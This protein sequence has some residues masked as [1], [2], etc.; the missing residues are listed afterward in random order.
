MS[1][2]TDLH[3][4]TPGNLIV[5]YQLDTTPIG[6]SDILHF[7]A[8]ANALGG[9]L[10]WGGVTY[11]HFPLEATGFERSGTGG[12]PRPK[13]VVANVDGL[14]GQFGRSLGGLEGAKLVRT[15]TFMKYLDPANFPGG[16]NPS[17]DSN[18]YIDREVWFISRR[19]SENRI[20]IEYELAASF[21]LGNVKLPRRQIVQ[22]VCTWRY[23]SA[24]CGYSGGPVADVKDVATAD[25][26]KDVCGKRL[27]SCKLRF[28]ATSVLPYGGFPGAGLSR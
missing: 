7:F 9:N 10:V 4:L 23:R 26:T 1:I 18:Q 8:D 27:G 21:D 14:I 16:V 13:L 6:G 22:N 24:E 17:A 3:S 5:L 28:G 11:T 15:R 25:V 19:A 20:F 2:V 12:S